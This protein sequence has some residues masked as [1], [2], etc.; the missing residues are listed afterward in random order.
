MWYNIRNFK[1]F[2]VV[3]V[4]KDKNNK[5]GKSG[6]TKMNP[7][8]EALL[9]GKPVVKGGSGAKVKRDDKTLKTV[10]VDEPAVTN[11]PKVV[12]P[13]QTVFDKK[14][15]DQ[16]FEDFA[17]GDDKSFDELLL[18]DTNEIMEEEEK[19]VY[20]NNTKSDKK[21][22]GQ[23]GEVKKKR[24]EKPKKKKIPKKKVEK[25][26]T[27]VSAKAIPESNDYVAPVQNVEPVQ[28]VASVEE[29]IRPEGGIPE[30]TAEPI[31]ESQP[32]IAEESVVEPV[33]EPT[34]EVANESGI[35]EEKPEVVDPDNT[36]SF[37]N[38]DEGSGINPGFVAGGLGA[39]AG[40]A[41][42]AAAAGGGGSDDSGNKSEW[43]KMKNQIKEDHEKTEKDLNAPS[44]GE[45]DLQK[46]EDSQEPE[47]MTNENLP[48]MGAFAAAVLGGAALGAGVAGATS[49]KGSNDEPL[50]GEVTNHG[51]P[52]AYA[53]GA[54][55][56]DELV[57]EDDA[58]REEVF[59][60]IKKYT[61]TG[62][63]VIVLLVAIFLFQI[64]QRIFGAVSDFLIG[65]GSQ[66]EITSED[67]SQTDEPYT[68][69][70]KGTSAIQSI[71][72]IGHNRGVKLE[73][74][75]S[76]AQAALLTGDDNAEAINV[77][78]AIATGFI[79]GVTNVDFQNT[80]RIATYMNV[81]MRLQ[82]GFATDIHQMLNSASN[83][84]VTLEA[85]ISELDSLQEEAITTLRELNEKKD[86]LKISFNEVTALKEKL[87]IDFFVATEK[88][89]GN[90]ANYLLEEFID[91]SQRQ[92]DL[93]A[94]YNALNSLAELFDYAILNM[95][96]R[97]K[98]IKYNR[99]ALVKGVQ[100]IDIIGSDLELII[101]EGGL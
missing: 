45:Q 82:N 71:F 90:K 93:K 97:I 9:S 65:D 21:S 5:N 1:T 38:Q 47:E 43:D 66:T 28:N 16:P 72:V 26:D 86:N 41:G 88:L 100:V 77:S 62:C 51:E 6:K 25:K 83:R 80:D 98:D 33:V 2:N 78:S 75:D 76:G 92:V 85:H 74:F 4:Q 73:N 32:E 99:E 54:A 67:E 22:I 40:A 91:T 7:F 3:M 19:M 8:A 87:E 57:D 34:S 24:E 11:G 12:I 20:K 53:A 48:K 95:D 84:I 89:E 17:E 56:Q 23:D 52:G 94:E 42:M 55:T 59:R 31:V 79:T 46:S 27:N 30:S 63:A 68:V 70:G 39:A 64:P 49:D 96:A 69:S 81:L 35:V 18:G 61:A 60:I 29:Q 10:Q 15:Q 101:Q 58:E 50:E 13:D 44:Q 36:V 14:S 37:D